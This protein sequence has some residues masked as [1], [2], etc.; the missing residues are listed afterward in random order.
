MNKLRNFTTLGIGAGLL[1]LVTASPALATSSP[2]A[3]K[4]LSPFGHA[5]QMSRFYTGDV[6]STGEFPGT[7]LCLHTG[8]EFTPAPVDQ[9]A[10]K[11]HVYVLSMQ[12]GSMVHPLLAGDP[13]TLKKLPK[14]VGKKVIVD[15]KYYESIGMLVAGNIR[16]GA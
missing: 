6:G 11:D 2:R 5:M 14:L 12:D 7:L 1:T 9:C 10:K 8:R 13:Q 16:K 4:A 3:A 15:G